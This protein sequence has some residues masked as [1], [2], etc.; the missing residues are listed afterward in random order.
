MKSKCT[1]CGSVC[2]KYDPTLLG[3]DGQPLPALCKNHNPSFKQ[4]RRE[5]TK[6]YYRTVDGKQK[7]RDAQK[8]YYENTKLARNKNNNVPIDIAIIVM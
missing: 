6:N 3:D 8:R 1:Q 2:L 7:V 4:H 5:Y